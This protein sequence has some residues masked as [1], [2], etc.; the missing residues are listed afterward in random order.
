MP[1]KLAVG[2]AIY[3]YRFFKEINSKGPFHVSNDNQP[4]PLY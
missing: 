2:S 1:K 3:R 4:D